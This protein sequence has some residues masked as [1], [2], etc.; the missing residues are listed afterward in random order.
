MVFTLKLRT[1]QRREV[2]FAVEYENYEELF[3][4]LDERFGDSRIRGVI[5]IGGLIIMKTIQ[6]I[7]EVI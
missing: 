1:T 2:V 4:E 3:D 7:E 5:G 6:K